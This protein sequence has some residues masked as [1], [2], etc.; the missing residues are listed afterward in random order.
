MSLG[1]RWGVLPRWQEQQNRIK[2]AGAAD[3]FQQ[4]MGQKNKIAIGSIL[5]GA[6]VFALKI[7]AYWVTGS[8]AL[9]SDALESVVNV[10][11]AVIAYGA[12]R[13]G[14]KP[15]DA[16]HPYGHHKAEYFSAVL[17]GVLIVLAALAIFREAY[18][19]YLAQRP[20]PVEVS[21]FL[22]NGAATVLN[23]VWAY[24]LIRFGR[25]LLSPALAADGRHLFGDVLSSLGVIVGLGIAILTGST[26]LDPILGAMVAVYVLWSGWSIL[27]GSIGGLMDEAVPPAMLED[28]RKI[29]A[30]NAS[31]ALEAHDLR[32][33]RAGGALFMDF[34]LVVPGTMSVSEAHTI[35]DD[36]EK[37]LRLQHPGAVISIH[38][39][40]DDKAKHSGIVVL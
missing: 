11:A 24:V 15:A 7:A 31:G 35:C 26:V 28:L 21:G 2:V 18:L 34:H 14:D 9:F 25:R 19:G 36:I 13:L 5:I 39:E 12:V 30:A 23:A 1:E 40:P 37:A 29:I 32:T 22:F 10:A 6:I 27:K 38:V 17:E 20:P 8:V 33:R 16:N 3:S 4:G